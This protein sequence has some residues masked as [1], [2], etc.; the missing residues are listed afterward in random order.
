MPVSAAGGETMARGG[1]WPRLVDDASC[2]RRKLVGIIN[3]MYKSVVLDSTLRL[4]AIV[5]SLLPSASI[6]C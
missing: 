2:D 1:P 5:R 6:W 4:A 3:Y